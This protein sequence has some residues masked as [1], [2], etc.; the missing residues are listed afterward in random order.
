[1]ESCVQQVGVFFI[2]FF[3]SCC[4]DCET[5]VKKMGFSVVFV[6]FFLVKVE[7][8]ESSVKK[9]LCINVLFTRL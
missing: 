3:L 2:I 9:L 7:L 8:G 6:I 5:T 1:M 4:N